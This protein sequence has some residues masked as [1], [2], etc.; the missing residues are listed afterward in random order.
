[1]AN[2]SELAFLHQKIFELETILTKSSAECETRIAAL[3]KEA[4]E[5]A[6]KKGTK[7]GYTL[8]ELLRSINRIQQTAENDTLAEMGWTLNL[9]ADQE[10]RIVE[11]LD[12]F[13]RRKHEL[14]VRSGNEKR[15]PAARRGEELNTARREAVGELRSVLSEEQYRRMIEHEYDQRLGLRIPKSVEAEAP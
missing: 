11:I 2:K 3:K 13:K 5:K 12:D 7:A 15:P 8:G 14:L 4:Q 1:M 10:S 6:G 9:E